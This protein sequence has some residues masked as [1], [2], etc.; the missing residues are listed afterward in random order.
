[1]RRRLLAFAAV[2]LAALAV[3]AVV[4][5]RGGGEQKRAAPTGDARA[6][7][8]AYAPRDAT[9]IVGVDTGTPAAGLIVPELVPR[10]T[11]GAL[12]AVDVQPL[13]GNEA[14]VALFDARARRGQLSVVARDADA[15][16]ALAR[17]LRPAGSYRGA[18]LYAGP[19][20]SAVAIRGTAVVA[21]PDQATVRRALDVRAEPRA[22]LT[23]AQFDGRLADLPRT[24]PVRAV[25]DAKAVVAS[26]LNGV[27]R[28]RWG[29]SL[30]NGAA[31]LQARQGGLSV[32]FRLQTDAKRINDADLPI[33]PG[34]RP[35]RMRGSA[36]LLIGVGDFSRLLRFLRRTDPARFGAIDSLQTG[37]PSFLRVDVDGLL[38]GLTGDATISSSDLLKH[39]LVRTDP[40]D[41]DAFRAPLQRL[42]TISGL[43]QRLG[44]DNIELDEEPG[45]AYRLRIDK[46]LVLRAGVF[47][48]TLVATNQARA[49]LRNAAAAPPAAPVPGAAGALTARMQASAARGLLTSTFGLPPEARLVLD[50]I[51][52]LTAWARAER[53]GVRGEL[54]LAVR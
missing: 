35:P 50:R 11:N 26:R 30:G 45:D 33:A 54:A 40:R 18:T 28:S 2:A 14:V 8:L 47:G 5:T 4:L 15:L 46:R 31:V 16:R 13:L 38:N 42:S 3:V 44:I 53:D 25:F 41:P 51:G 10:L 52:D 37:L 39:L 32:P 19:R 22:H 17:R 1:V 23:G 49:N 43:L 34:A 29:R 27:L 9:V 20:G 12:R 24:A 21:A 6:E 36:P 7:A 48:R